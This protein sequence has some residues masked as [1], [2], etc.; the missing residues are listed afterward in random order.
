[1]FPLQAPRS[2]RHNPSNQPHPRTF[3]RAGGQR[4]ITLLVVEFW[5]QVM[6]LSHNPKYRAQPRKT[7]AESAIFEF[8]P[9]S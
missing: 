1:M 6:G 8:R 5:I 2:D 9:E 4:P 3:L 7:E